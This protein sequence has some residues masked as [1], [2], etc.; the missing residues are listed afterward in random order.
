M[1]L[2]FIESL[3]NNKISNK[4]GDTAMMNLVEMVVGPDLTLDWLQKKNK[5]FIELGAQFVRGTISIAKFEEFVFRGEKATRKMDSRSPTQQLDAWEDLLSILDYKLKS[6][7]IFFPQVQL[8][9]EHQDPYDFDLLKEKIKFPTI[10]AVGFSQSEEKILKEYCSSVDTFIPC[11]SMDTFISIGKLPL[12]FSK[13]DIIVFQGYSETGVFLKKNF[14]K[15]KKEF[16]RSL[17]FLVDRKTHDSESYFNFQKED[18]I[19]NPFEKKF[20]SFYPGVEYF[21]NLRNEKDIKG[22]LEYL[23]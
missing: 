17:W 8:F 16:S 13:H 4:Q 20:I 23:K 14:L 21:I 12:E 19:P 18:E 2:L 10:C 5:L 9:I 3:K 7:M 1:A 22:L 15:L 6:G 11:S